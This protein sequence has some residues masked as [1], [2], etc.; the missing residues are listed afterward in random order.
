[1]TP[2]GDVIKLR[3]LKCGIKMT[4]QNFSI[5]KLLPPPEQIPGCSPGA[6]VKKYYQTTKSLDK[7][8]K[9]F[10]VGY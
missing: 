6:S 4:S 5:F 8:S 2:F 10:S 9:D 7:I 3:H 1:M